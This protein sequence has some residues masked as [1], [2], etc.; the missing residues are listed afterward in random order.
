MKTTDSPVIELLKSEIRI[1]KSSTNAVYV[2]IAQQII[3]LIQKGYLSVG[4][5]LPGTRILAVTIGIHRKTAVAVYEE[6]AAQGWV[7]SIP[8]KGTYIV[9]PENITKIKAIHQQNKN[10]IASKNTGF[11]FEASFNLA[12]IETLFETEF[13]ANDGHPDVRLHPVTQFSKW[14][15]AAMKRKSLVSKWQQSGTA[16]TQFENQLCNFLNASRGFAIQPKNSLS[17]RSSEMSL[18]LIAQLLIRPKDV[19]LVGNLGNYAANMVF[20]QAG[21]T[22]KTLPVD[23]YGL[24]VNAIEELAKKNTIRCVY[25][26]SNRHY[27]TTNT[28]SAERRLQLLALAKKLRF[29]IIED[30]FDY[31]FQFDGSPILPMA[32]SDTDG[33]IIYLGKLGQSLFPSFQI[34]FMIAPENFILEAKNYLQ[35]LDSKGDLIQEQVLAELIHEGEIHRLLKKNTLVYKKRRDTM[36]LALENHF[37]DTIAFEKPSGGLALWIRFKTQISL[38]QLAEKTKKMGL[39]LP[40]TLLYQDKNSCAIRLGFGHWNEE[41]IEMVVEKLRLG[42]LEFFS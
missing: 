24:Q 6:L 27:P 12:P 42:Y 22:I 31:D 40:K 30:D 34:G 38:V 15:G 19:V 14:Y 5:L 35:M 2:Q 20:Q 36:C 25:L 39:F 8:N 16:P 1:E 3:Q 17:T 33:L 10:Q 29:A 26:N 41:E 9:T 4:S 13:I 28:L 37:G 7:N 11:P 21:A 23:A 18:Y 32:S